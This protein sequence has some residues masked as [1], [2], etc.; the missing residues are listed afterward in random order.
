MSKAKPDNKKLESAAK[1]NKKPFTPFTPPTRPQSPEETDLP[2]IEPGDFPTGG[3]RWRWPYPWDLMIAVSLHEQRGVP[4]VFPL[5]V[6]QLWGFHD[7]LAFLQSA[8]SMLG[9]SPSYDPRSPRDS[10][11]FARDLQQFIVA[12]RSRSLKLPQYVC[13]AFSLQYPPTALKSGGLKV[14]EERN[15]RHTIWTACNWVLSQLANMQADRAVVKDLF[16][17]PNA[18][19]IVG[20]RAINA[21]LT[22]DLPPCDYGDMPSPEKSRIIP[23]FFEAK[24]PEL[25]EGMGPTQDRRRGRPSVPREMVLEEVEREAEAMRQEVL[26]HKRAIEQAY[27]RR[28]DSLHQKGACPSYQ[29]NKKVVDDL[30]KDADQDGITFLCRDERKKRKTE[31]LI[32]DMELH[33]VRLYCD[34]LG[35]KSGIFRCKLPDDTSIYTGVLFPELTAV[36]G[37]YNRPP[38]KTAGQG[39]K[40]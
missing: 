32:G 38:E 17:H 37:E 33:S 1:E 25:P 29:Q 30:V 16:C 6:S 15:R 24:L 12:N 23:P 20:L 27:Q 31:E 13:V 35:S 10:V 5:S 9:G 28:L 34:E 40:A 39:E 14:P 18:T 2:P 4:P 7:A 21:F 11:D 3:G 8:L 36:L 26:P 22:N 19:E